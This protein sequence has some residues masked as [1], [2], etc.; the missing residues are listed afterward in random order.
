MALAPWKNWQAAD[1]TGTALPGN[2]EGL[3]VQAFY[4]VGA[5]ERTRTS[6][7]LSAST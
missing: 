1:L 6:T 4:D 2:E 5:Q 7:P 3:R